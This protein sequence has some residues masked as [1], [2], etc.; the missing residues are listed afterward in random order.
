MTD[1]ERLAVL[2]DLRRATAAFQLRALCLA[3]GVPVPEAKP[4]PKRDKAP[5]D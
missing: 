1:K 5:C 3:M 4:E 2:K